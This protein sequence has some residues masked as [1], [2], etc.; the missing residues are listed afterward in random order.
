MDSSHVEN[1]LANQIIKVSFHAK[2]LEVPNFKC[3]HGL[4]FFVSLLSEHY[5]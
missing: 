1:A 5:I 2:I 3:K 4:L